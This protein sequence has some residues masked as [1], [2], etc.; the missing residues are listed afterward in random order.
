VA[1]EDGDR[2][3]V[4][5]RPATVNV[6]GAVYNQNSFLHEPGLRVAD[7][8]RHAGGPTRNADSGQAF[9]IRADGRVLPRRGAG[10]FETLRL[11]PGDS[12][13]V[14]E[15]LFKGSILRGLRDWTQV[16]SQLALGAAAVNILR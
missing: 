14:P 8:L 2:F 15:Q 7:Y 16:F 6:L 10:K 3:V 13:V 11:S 4:P 5:A 9:I 1:L 12:V